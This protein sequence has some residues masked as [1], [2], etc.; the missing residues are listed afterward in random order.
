MRR[1][2]GLAENIDR[3]A[4]GEAQRRERRRLGALRPL[5]GERDETHRK[6]LADRVD[7]GLQPDGAGPSTRSARCSEGPR[8]RRRL[9]IERERRERGLDLARRHRSL[10]RQ[11]QMRQARVSG[12]CSIVA[13]PAASMVDERDAMRIA[14]LGLRHRDQRAGIADRLAPDGSAGDADGRARHKRC[15]AEKCRAERRVRRPRECAARRL[16]I[17]VRRRHGDGR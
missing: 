1:L 10:R 2:E 4:L 17:R 8:L 9:R 12:R 14:D 16:R 7:L 11:A 6:F 5:D 13:A 3:R 15:P